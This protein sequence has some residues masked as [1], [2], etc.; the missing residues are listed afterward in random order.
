MSLAIGLG[1]AL[2]YAADALL[3]DPRRGHP[4]AGFGTIAARLEPL[5]YADRRTAGVAHVGLLVGAA[6]GLGL[7]V[8]RLGRGHPAALTVAT[9]AATWTVLGGRSLR[10]EATTI[11]GQLAA[12]DL[13]AARRQVRNL[14]GRETSGARTRRDRPGHG[15]VGRREHLRRGGGAAVLGRRGRRA[16]PAR[17]PGGEHAGR[18]DRAPVAALRA[19]RLGRGPAGRRRQLG[20]GAG[21]RPGGGPGRTAGGRLTGGGA[22]GRAARRRPA[23]EPERRRGRGGVRRRAGD[24]AGRPQRVRRP[25]RGARRARRRPRGRGRRHRAGQPAGPGGLRDRPRPR[26]PA[27]EWRRR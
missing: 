21:G 3:G 18:H 16:G 19:V 27:P 24:P 25:G 22:A 2:G 20:A 9:A 12:G 26:C 11:A 17:L 13:P 6:V 4:V 23:P 5:V 7:G 15:G 1:L 14:V 10:R 8:Q